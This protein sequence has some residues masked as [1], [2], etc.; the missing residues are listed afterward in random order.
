MTRINPDIEINRRRLLSTSAALLG[1]GG[2]AGGNVSALEAFGRKDLDEYEIQEVALEYAA[3][4]VRDIV[5]FTTITPEHGFQLFLAR[6]VA[7]PDAVP[8]SVDVLTDAEHGVH[9]PS[10]ELVS[11]SPQNRHPSLA[12][13]WPLRFSM[14]GRTFEIRAGKLQ[15]VS[16]HG[17]GTEIVET[18]SEPIA[19][20]ESDLVGSSGAVEPQNVVKCTDLPWVTDWCF[21]VDGRDD[22]HT[23]RCTNN[24][25][26]PSMPHAHLAVFRKGGSGRDGINMWAGLSGGCFYVGEE[27]YLGQCLRV[28]SSGGG[29]PSFSDVKDAYENMIDRAADAA[30]IAIPALVIAALAYILAGLTLKPPTGIPI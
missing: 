17:R 20:T 2:V 5:A 23:P 15:S 26:P 24:P 4:P 14:D 28:C 16:T 9:A 8:D 27:H 22:G 25:T 11:K 12:A 19:I 30:G 18:D 7:S 6:G 3:H 13:N 21:R 10:W 29:L 1:A